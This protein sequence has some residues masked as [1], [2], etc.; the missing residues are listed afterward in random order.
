MLVTTL[1]ATGSTWKGTHGFAEMSDF[2]G[3]IITENLIVHSPKTGRDVMFK[4]TAAVYDKTA[5]D[6][7]SLEYTSISLLTENKRVFKLSFFND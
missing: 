6:L 5:E 2:H 4:K 1:D 3:Q 7:L